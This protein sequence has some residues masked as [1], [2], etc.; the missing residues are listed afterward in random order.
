LISLS[1][2]SGFW[3]TIGPFL[4]GILVGI[5]V[6]LIIGRARTRRRVNW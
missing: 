3:F 6:G 2:S 4:L 1:F 5:L